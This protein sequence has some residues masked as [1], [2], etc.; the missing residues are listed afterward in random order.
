MH[1]GKAE[2]DSPVL[3]LIPPLS[4][5]F[6]LSL[7]FLASFLSCGFINIEHFDENFLFS[8][9]P[10]SANKNILSSPLSGGCCFCRSLNATHFHFTGG[11]RQGRFKFWAARE[12]AG[13]RWNR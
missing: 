12:E 5:S 6:P 10:L 8:S 4:S 7:P 11:R 3:L 1:H 9:R 13:Y 2:R